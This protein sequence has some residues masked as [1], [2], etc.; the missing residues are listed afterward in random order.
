MVYEGTY[1][2]E[3]TNYNPN[4]KTN[5]LLKDMNG[6]TNSYD[7]RLWLQRNGQQLIKQ[8]RENA[9]EMVKLNCNCPQCVRISN[10]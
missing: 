9:R 1:S 7:Y 2:R 6:I 5:Q 4:C 8:Q 10:R 3:L